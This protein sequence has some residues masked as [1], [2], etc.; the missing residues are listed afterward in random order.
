MGYELKAEVSEAVVR[1]HSNRL[2]KI[3][4]GVVEAG[5]PESGMFPDSLRTLARIKGTQ[6]CKNSATQ[7][8]ERHFRVMVSG[9]RSTCWTPE[10]SLPAAVVKLYDQQ[11]A[12][13][14]VL[15]QGEGEDELDENS[16][17]GDDGNAQTVEE[18]QQ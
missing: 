2:R 18:M 11:V 16:S 8:Q 1:V 10:S 14:K 5:T 12:D 9:Q 4:E 15:T 17:E 7:E 3:P 13:G 6:T